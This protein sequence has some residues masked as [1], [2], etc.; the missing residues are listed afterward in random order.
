MIKV[1]IIVP[2]YN[3]EQYLNKCLHSLVNQTLEEIEII[4]VN[5]GST[6]GSQK[7]IDQYKHNSKIKTYSKENG[8]VSDARNYGMQFAVGEYIGFIDSDDFVE[9]DMYENM[10]LKAK[11]ENSDIVECNLRHTYPNAEDIEIGKEIYDKKEMLMFGRSVIWNKI[12]KREWLLNTNVTFPL[13]I[14]C[15]DVEFF[16]KLIPYISVYSYVQPA[17]IHYLQ[18]NTSQ[19]NSSTLKTLDVL[20]ALTN[21]KNFYI[22][23]GY[24]DEYKEAIE[25]FFARNLLCSSFIRMSRIG[26]AKDRKMALQLN[27]KLLIEHFPDWRKNQVL[28]EN[29]SRQAIF[30]KTVNNMTYPLYSIAFPFVFSLNKNIKRIFNN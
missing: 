10:Y 18:R 17:Y 3:V 16:I 25:F 11:E 24:Y 26:D 4:I 6:D 23:N 8:G 9:L 28:L 14:I 12:Y 29:K 7:I 27:W 2:V 13:G 15:E 1:S 20:K 5:D 30:M 19:N 22:E 21:I